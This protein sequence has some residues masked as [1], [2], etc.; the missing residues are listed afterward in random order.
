MMEFLTGSPGSKV[1]ERGFGFV[2]ETLG[3]TGRDGVIQTLYPLHPIWGAHSSFHWASDGV[4]L[5][6]GQRNLG[7]DSFFGEQRIK[8]HIAVTLMN[9]GSPIWARTRYLRINGPLY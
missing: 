2:A 3:I 5:T 1:K 8:G 9:A 6:S 4:K 7:T